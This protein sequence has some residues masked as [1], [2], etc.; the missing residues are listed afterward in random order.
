M[1]TS[2]LSA[3]LWFSAAGIIAVLCLIHHDPAHPGATLWGM[4]V[5]WIAAM[6]GIKDVVISRWERRAR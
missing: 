1:I 4:F 3:S 5:A 2:L 6:A